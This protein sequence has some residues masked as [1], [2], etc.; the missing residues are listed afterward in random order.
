MNLLLDINYAGL[1]VGPHVILINIVGIRVSILMDMA[2]WPMF[3]IKIYQFNG[4]ASPLCFCEELY[5]WGI[6]KTW[7]YEKF[8]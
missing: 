6:I 8:E 2:Y 3:L 1:Y 4:I 7:I 5:N